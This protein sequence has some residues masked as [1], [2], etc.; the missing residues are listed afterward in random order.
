MSRWCA[1]IDRRTGEVLRFGYCDFERDGAFDATREV[2]RYDE[3][4]PSLQRRGDP[5]SNG[6]VSIWK[7]ERWVSVVPSD[8]RQGDRKP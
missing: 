2:C 1:V 6:Q 5:W 8:H 7:D 3:R 4:A